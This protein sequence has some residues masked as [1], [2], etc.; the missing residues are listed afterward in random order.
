MLSL[1]PLVFKVLSRAGCTPG[2][3]VLISLF[4]HPNLHRNA[5]EGKREVRGGCEVQAG[6]GDGGAAEGS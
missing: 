5:S 4:S 6:G 1:L 2:T 3:G